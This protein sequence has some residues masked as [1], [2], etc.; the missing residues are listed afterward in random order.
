VTG[1]AGAYYLVA[2][3]PTWNTIA[4]PKLFR[5]PTRDGL[6]SWHP[7]SR[8]IICA[9]FENRNAIEVYLFDVFSGRLTEWRRYA[10]SEDAAELINATAI[11]PDGTFAATTQMVQDSA[12]VQ[13]NLP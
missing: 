10:P 8:R 6:L 3:D 11:T 13:L 1:R 7:D 4:E 9:R 5:P 12:L 2:L